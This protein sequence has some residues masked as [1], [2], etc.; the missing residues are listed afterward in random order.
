MLVVDVEVVARS[1]V[2]AASWEAGDAVAAT[3]HAAT[4]ANPPI[5]MD[6]LRDQGMVAPWGY[7]APE[8]E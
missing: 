2:A 4:T 1:C 8:G 6:S 7:L 5:D 3:A